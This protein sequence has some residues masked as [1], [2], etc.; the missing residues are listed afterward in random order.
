M[1]K[2]PSSQCRGPGVQ[3]LV[4]ELDPMCMLQIRVRMPQL[5]PGAAKINK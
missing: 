4:R 1:A 5:R 2:T 3:S